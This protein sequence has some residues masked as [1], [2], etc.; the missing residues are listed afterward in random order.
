MKHKITSLTAVSLLALTACGT[1]DTPDDDPAPQE[2]EEQAADTTDEDSGS[3]ERVDELEEELASVEDENETLEAQ[4]EELRAELEEAN[5]E[6]DEVAADD[7]DAETPSADGTLE[8]GESARITDWG[9]GLDSE[10]VATLTMNDIE[11]G[12]S[13]PECR[14]APVNDHYI[15]LNLTVEADEDAY[16]D[17]AVTQ[18]SFYLVDDENT[19]H[20]DEAQ[21]MEAYSCASTAGSI[22][23]VPPGTNHTGYILL[24]TDLT[25]GTIVYEGVG[26]DLRW[27]F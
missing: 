15:A 14:D 20:R 22:E 1:E 4:V 24:D 5:Q 21:T 26:E 16:D 3:D 7:D 18:F 17:V 23:W 2:Q 27:E 12:Y 11:L 13:N 8:V 25:E 10:E 6:D 9:E 19:I